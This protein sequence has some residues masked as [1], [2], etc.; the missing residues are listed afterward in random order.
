MPGDAL[1][2]PTDPPPSGGQSGTVADLPL[3]YLFLSLPFDAVLQWCDQDCL[4]ALGRCVNLPETSLSYHWDNLYKAHYCASLPR[5]V[6][7]KL[8]EA[9]FCVG[10]GELGRGLVRTFFL[11]SHWGTF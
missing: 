6:R 9:F 10:V 5:S 1:L 3:P 8:D 7:H 4:R 11:G 2:L